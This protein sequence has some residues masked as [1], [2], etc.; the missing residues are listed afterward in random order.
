MIDYR[1]EFSWRLDVAM[2]KRGVSVKDI[3]RKT[4][5]HPKTI[6][7]YLEGHATPNVEKLVP[8]A[9][10]LRVKTDWLCGMNAKEEQG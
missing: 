5:I 1:E 10:L 9:K 8:I 4:G 3:A 6:Y 7:R 2:T